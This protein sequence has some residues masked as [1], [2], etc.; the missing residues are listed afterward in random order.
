MRTTGNEDRRAASPVLEL[1]NDCTRG[2]ARGMT[3]T[4]ALKSGERRVVDDAEGADT[5]GF[6]VWFTATG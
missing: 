5:D 4:V 6:F 1:R 2:L 3:V